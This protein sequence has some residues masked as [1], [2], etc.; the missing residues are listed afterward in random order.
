MSPNRLLPC[1]VCGPR[2]RHL[3]KNCPVLQKKEMDAS[4]DI[5]NGLNGIPDAIATLQK[6]IRI[7]EALQP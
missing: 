1:P 6:A 3:P 4:R 2:K 7:L 5:G